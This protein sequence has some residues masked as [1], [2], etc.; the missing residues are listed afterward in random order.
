MKQITL[1]MAADQAAGFERYRKPTWRE[2][3]LAQMEKLVPWP[4]LGP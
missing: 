1:A 2:A 3:F 4:E